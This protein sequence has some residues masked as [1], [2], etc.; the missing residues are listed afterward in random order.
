M[1]ILALRHQLAVLQRTQP[2]RLHIHLLDRLLWVLLS[3]IWQGWREPLVIVKPETVIQW[4]RE[5]FRLFWRLKFRRKRPGRP[6]ITKEIKGLIRKMSLENPLWGAPRIHGELLKL[7]YQVAETSVA[8]YMVKP[9]KPP[10]Q[11]W[12]TFL[13]NHANCLAAMD[14]FTVPTLFFKVFHVLILLD[15]ERRRIIHFN[16]TTNPTAAW[17]AQQIRDAFPWDSTPRYLIH[18]RDPTFQG[19]CK[20]TLKVMGI[21]DIKIAPASP[22]QNAYCER[23]IGSIRRECL[24]HV[25][26]MNEA[27][28]R[29]TLTP[30]FI[31][32]HET[33]THLWLAKDCPEPR[34]VQPMGTGEVITIPHLSGLHHQYLRKA[35]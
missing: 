29:R 13:E 30:C 9:A 18:D 24:D 35:A 3:R 8:E 25:I 28:L 26:V 22:W 32:Y 5:G 23:V 14:F 17:V 20:D 2:R 11:P 7:G 33:L 12:K 19:T 31:Y 21:K 27:H 10:S 4:H 34:A 1:E 6:A 16:V 15:H